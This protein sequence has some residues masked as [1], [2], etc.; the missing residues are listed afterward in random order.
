MKELFATYKSKLI[1]GKSIADDINN[2]TKQSIT[3]FAVK[4]KLAILLASND[5]ASKVYVRLKARKAEA[6]GIET[7]IREFEESAGA[8]DLIDQIERWNNDKA[9]TGVLIQLPFYEHLKSET[10]R[11]V[12]SL[13]SKKDVDGLT[14]V[15][16][17]QSSHF[18]K[19]SIPPATAEAILE[20]L[21]VA[22]P[23]T[24]WDTILEKGQANRPLDGKHVALINNSLLIGR[25]LAS[26]LSG[27]GAT[28][29]IANSSTV[30]LFE[31]TKSTDILISATGETNLISQK[32]VKDGAILIDVTSKKVDGHIIGDFIISEELLEKVSY[33]TPVPGGVGPLTI[34]CLLRNVYRMS[35]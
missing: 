14:A 23:E 4:P 16:Q 17:G 35:I 15:M 28:V 26:I 12:N 29:T 7:V 34:A 20:C 2:A 22:I 1:N 19:D 10:S 13:D 30:K 33:I 24:N 5:E 9:V 32:S 21:H 3:T 8:S 31:Y 6:V 11:I 27:L 25:P 18:L